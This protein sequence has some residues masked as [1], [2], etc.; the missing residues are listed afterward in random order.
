MRLKLVK[1]VPPMRAGRRLAGRLAL[2]SIL[3][4]FLRPFIRTRSTESKILKGFH[5][6]CMRH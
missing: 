5:G 6:E 1:A 3:F 4:L 2:R